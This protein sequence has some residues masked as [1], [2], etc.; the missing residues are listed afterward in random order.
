MSNCRLTTSNFSDRAQHSLRCTSASRFERVS[1]DLPALWAADSTT[2]QDR[3]AIA[4]LL[5]DEVVVTVE[6]E[7]DRTEVELHWAG[8]FVSHHALSRSVQTYEQLSNY[9][10]LVA[11]IEQLRGERKTLTEIAASLNAEGFRPPKRARNS[12]KV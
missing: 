11:H 5:L 12:P 7:S 6:G 10:E 9:Q 1:D 8:G 2:P 4:R 3:Q